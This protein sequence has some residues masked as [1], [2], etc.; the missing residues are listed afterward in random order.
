MRDYQR[1]VELAQL[2]HELALERLKEEER[3]QKEMHEL[4]MEYLKEKE[5]IMSEGYGSTLNFGGGLF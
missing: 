1:N 2:Y 3:I 5:R 4:W